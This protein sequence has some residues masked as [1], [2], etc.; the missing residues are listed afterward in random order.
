MRNLTNSKTLLVCLLISLI[1]HIAGTYFFRGFLSHDIDTE[2]FKT[3]LAN[4]PVMFKPRRLNT[5]KQNF[6]APE[7]DFEYLPSKS[8]D[9]RMLDPDLALLSKPLKIE[10]PVLAT[11]LRTFAAG[12]KEENPLLDRVRMLSPSTLGLAQSV[13]IPSMDLVRIADMARANKH[14]SAVIMDLSSRRDLAG[15]VN[16]T[17]LQLYG[18]GSGRGALDALSRYLRDN[19]LILANV[20]EKTYQYFL[21]ENLFKDPI[22]FLIEGGGRDRWNDNIVTRFSE[23]EILRLG[24]YLRKG[25]FLYIEGGNIYLREMRD[26]IKAALGDEAFLFSLPV[27]HPIYHSFYEFPSGFP[28]EKKLGNEKADEL[29]VKSQRNL[30]SKWYYPVRLSDQ[31]VPQ[32]PRTYL[33]P[34]SEDSEQL[35]KLGVWGVYLNGRLVAILCDIGFSDQWVGSFD[36]DTI[37]DNPTTLSLMVATNMVVY[38]LTN[39]MGIS[40]K[41]PPPTWANKRPLLG[42]GSPENISG[43]ASEYDELNDEFS[44]MLDGSLAIVQAPLNSKIE[45]NLELSINGRYRVE[46]FKRGY[47][48]IVIHNLQAGA[49]WIEIGYGGKNKQLEFELQG[50]KVLTVNFVLDRFLFFNQLRVEMLDQQVEWGDWIKSFPDLRLD[51]IYLSGDREWL[52]LDNE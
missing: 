44:L 21:S 31:L 49:H 51:E 16:F 14:H 9:I 1:V 22:H 52:E 41:L 2:V 29:Y 35:S 15:Y 6:R 11:E 30:D 26:H 27:L 4:A 43:D 34:N 24:E 46:L 32:G 33:N 12:A 50:G 40:I 19:T 36:V 23:D 8:P 38:A 28:G 47:S 45:S 17:Q 10:E 42:I 48:G 25:G 37:N 13:G 18:T 20:R 7:I 5:P 39:P 3:R